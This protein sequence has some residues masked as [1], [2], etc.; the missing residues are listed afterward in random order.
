MASRSSRP[1][2]EIILRFTLGFVAKGVIA[3][4]EYL[5]AALVDLFGCLEQDNGY[6]DDAGSYFEKKSEF[7]GY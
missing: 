4:A 1:L 3:A 2:L 7:D 5:Q 6:N